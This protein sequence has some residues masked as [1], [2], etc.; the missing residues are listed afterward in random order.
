[1]ERAVLLSEG[2]TITR[3]QLERFLI[4]GS[5]SGEDPEIKLPAQGVDLEQVERSFLMQALKRT[6]YVQKEAAK[7]LGVSSRVLN[8]KIKRFG[9]THPTWKQNR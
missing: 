4:R 3:E 9:V 1:M 6:R 2:D 7:L 8:Y 5:A